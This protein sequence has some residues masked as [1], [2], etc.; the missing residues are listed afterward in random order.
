[1]QELV[2]RKLAKSPVICTLII[3]M[4]SVL[5]DTSA[6][7]KMFKIALSTEKADHQAHIVELLAVSHIL[8]HISLEPS[9]SIEHMALLLVV[10]S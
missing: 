4:A 8:L 10:L 6:I 7:S 3:R 5:V 1:M 2:Q 9:L